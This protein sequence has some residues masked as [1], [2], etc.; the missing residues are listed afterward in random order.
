MKHI[1]PVHM[2]DT[3]PAVSQLH[4]GLWFLITTESIEDGQLK[5]IKS[6]LAPDI[7]TNTFGLA[8]FEIVQIY[9]RNMDSRAEFLKKYKLKP[10]VTNGDVDE[11]TAHALNC[12]I[13]ERRSEIRASRRSLG[14]ADIPDRD[15]K[16]K[17]YS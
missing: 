10:V 8:T 1:Q 17:K 3:G 13:L 2:G 14:S 11:G 9:Q 5:I 7:Q 12:F 16:D 4:G 15:R 6:E